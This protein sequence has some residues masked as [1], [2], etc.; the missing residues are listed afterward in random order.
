MCAWWWWWWWQSCAGGPRNPEVRDEVRAFLMEE[1][2]EVEYVPL[3]ERKRLM[4]KQRREITKKRLGVSAL[5]EEVC[6]RVRE[7]E[8]ES[9]CVCV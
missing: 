4:E 5:P 8:R 7:R 3:R 9:V 6:M 1:D 2:A